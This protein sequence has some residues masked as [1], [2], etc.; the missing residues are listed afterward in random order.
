ISDRYISTYTEESTT[1][2]LNLNTAVPK[3]GTINI[4]I[5]DDVEGVELP[6]VVENVNFLGQSMSPAVEQKQN[7]PQ[8][9]DLPRDPVKEKTKGKGKKK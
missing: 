4:H 2:V 8:E 6:F 9:K 5:H 3:R 7:K 1:M